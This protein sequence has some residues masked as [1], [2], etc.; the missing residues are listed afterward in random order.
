MS[1]N[2]IRSVIENDDVSG[3]NSNKAWAIINFDS[4]QSRLIIDWKIIDRLIEIRKHEE[5]K[6]RELQSK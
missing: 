4:N 2:T 6:C 3:L 5:D 1:Q